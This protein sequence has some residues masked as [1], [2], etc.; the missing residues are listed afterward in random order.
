MKCQ[1]CGVRMCRTYYQ[2][3]RKWVSTNLYICPK[4]GTVVRVQELPP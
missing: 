4:C 2:Q 3:R 1:K